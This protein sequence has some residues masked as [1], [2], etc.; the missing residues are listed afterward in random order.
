KILELCRQGFEK[1]AVEN[2]ADVLQIGKLLRKYCSDF[3]LESGDN[4]ENIVKN[5]EYRVSCNLR[6]YE[7][8]KN[9][10]IPLEIKD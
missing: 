5:T 9:T 7:K 6:M 8:E 2:G 10:T 1:T 4:Y 3:Y